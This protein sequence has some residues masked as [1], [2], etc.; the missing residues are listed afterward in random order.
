MSTMLS[1]SRRRYTT[2][3]KLWLI[4][5]LLGAGL[6]WL[7]LWPSQR[8]IWKSPAPYLQDIQA[9]QPQV[10]H[11]A[12]D[13]HTWQNLILE[14]QE[15]PLFILSRRLPPPPPKEEPPAQ[16]DRWDR[17]TL[18]G[19][20]ASGKNAGAFLLV[21]GQPLRLLQGQDLDGWTLR[22]VQPSSI[23]VARGDK[24]RQLIVQK[25]DLSQTSAAGRNTGAPASSPFAIARPSAPG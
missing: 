22:T 25:K 5:V 7:W 3:Q 9:M 23:E 17:V 16:T 14:A 12:D 13:W 8:P 24:K 6:A 20:Y 11:L 4:S 10:P 1:P 21:D 18:L 19:T 15:R 2:I